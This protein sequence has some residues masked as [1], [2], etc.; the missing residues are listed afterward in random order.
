MFNFLLHIVLEYY[1]SFESV[2]GKKLH[3]I[4]LFIFIKR[5]PNHYSYSYQ[6]ELWWT[7][8]FC[9]VLVPQQNYLIHSVRRQDHTISV[10]AGCGKFSETSQTSFLLST[11]HHTPS[12]TLMVLSDFGVTLPD[13]SNFKTSS[14][15]LENAFLSRE[16]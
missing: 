11:M 2:W 10:T 6:S 4:I 12:V 8:S 15:I 3:K 5:C 13:F 16:R 7:N 14:C 9:I 1:Y